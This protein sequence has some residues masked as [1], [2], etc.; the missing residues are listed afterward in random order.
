MARRHRPRRA[1]RTVLLVGEGDTDV[2]FL[3]HLKGLYNVRNCGVAC[4][5]RNAHGRGPEHV[6][7]YTERQSRTADYDR[8]AAFLDTDIPWPQ[9]MRKRAGQK[10]IELLPSEPCLEG[11]LLRI[12]GQQV[13]ALSNECKTLLRDM[14]LKSHSCYEEHFPRELLDRR[15]VK[16]ETLERLIRLLSCP[17]DS[18]QGN[19]RA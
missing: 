2:A 19:R 17:N 11:F 8:K 13:P 10:Y 16:I 6:L 5:I 14:N 4:T 1:Q 15:K 9:R 3:K 18:V 7:D 12:L